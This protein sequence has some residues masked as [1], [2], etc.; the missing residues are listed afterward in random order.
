MKPRAASFLLAAA[1][2]VPSLVP[3]AARAQEVVR[4]TATAGAS[5]STPT[6]WRSAPTRSPC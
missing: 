2:A 1:L 3:H 6:C 5:R 4:V